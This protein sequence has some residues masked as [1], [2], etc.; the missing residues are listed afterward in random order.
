[1]RTVIFT[2]FFMMILI[3]C[4]SSIEPIS[5]EGKKYSIYGTLD[6]D[7]KANY[8][9]VYDTKKL[10]TPEETKELNVNTIF[11]NLENG[12]HHFLEHQVIKFEHIY[13][14]NYKLE[15]PLDFNS[16]YKITIED[17][18]GYKDSLITKTPEKAEVSRVPGEPI[19]E[20][21]DFFYIELTNIKI[22]DGEDLNSEIGFRF[23]NKWHWW[24]R[25]FESE[26][27]ETK[28]IL[29]LGWSPGLVMTAVLG[30]DD[31]HVIDWRCTDFESEI[32]RFRYSHVG[33]VEG[34]PDAEAEIDSTGIPGDRKVVLIK[35]EGEFQIDLGK[36][37]FAN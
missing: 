18:D 10:Q 26:Y 15:A 1:M 35:Y 28:D 16:R 6:M 29:K 27:D 36:A 17:E 34:N 7:G 9:R 33:Y 13:T 23:N 31:T 25:A 21:G 4:D 2:S 37:L 22:D 3:G 14:H 30:R 5:K 12:S 24:S 20:C 32:M 8:I 11:T 19:L